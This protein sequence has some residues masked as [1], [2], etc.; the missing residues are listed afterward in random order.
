M[1]WTP[2]E[3][4]MRLSST[5]RVKE[6]RADVGTFEKPC[7]NTKKSLKQNGRLTAFI[8]NIVGFWF[9]SFGMLALTIWLYDKRCDR[10]R[11]NLN[12]YHR[13]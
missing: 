2:A 12:L 13:K 5:D 6:K 9:A 3:D 8:Q 10:I 1:F 4:W 7:R 11:G